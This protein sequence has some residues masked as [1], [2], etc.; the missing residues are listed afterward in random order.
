[1]ELGSGI[2]LLGIVVLKFCNPQ[3]YIFSD[4]SEEVLKLL[5]TNIKINFKSH[6]ALIEKQQLM[7]ADINNEEANALS[8]DVILGTGT[9]SLTL[10]NYIDYF[11]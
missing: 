1:M 7:W 6:D 9:Y 4:K 3:K 10:I 5:S 11:I 8:P 2:G